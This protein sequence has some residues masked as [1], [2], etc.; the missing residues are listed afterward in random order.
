MMA[1]LSDSVRTLTGVAPTEGRKK[2]RDLFAAQVADNIEERSNELEALRSTLKTV[3]GMAQSAQQQIGVL[4]KRIN[5]MG[6]KAKQK[7]IE[8]KADSEQTEDKG[9]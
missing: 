1:K 2:Y 3:N 8:N 5:E 9:E 7:A 6:E 4:T